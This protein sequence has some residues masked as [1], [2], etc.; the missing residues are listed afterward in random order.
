MPSAKE[1]RAGYHAA[2]KAA[3]RPAPTEEPGRVMRVPSFIL[4]DAM[5][6]AGVACQQLADKL[7]ARR[8]AAALACLA[9]EPPPG[10]FGVPAAIGAGGQ[11]RTPPPTVSPRAE[12]PFRRLY[13]LWNL[14]AKLRGRR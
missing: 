12:S 2:L 6:A 9:G 14:R 1:W 10:R 4:A 3:T 5:D 13:A 8:S 7:A 11:V